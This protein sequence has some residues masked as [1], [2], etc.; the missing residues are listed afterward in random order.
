MSHVIGKGNVAG[1]RRTLDCFRSE[2]EWLHQLIARLLLQLSEIETAAPHP[3]RS[4][5]F[6]PPHLEAE[7]PQCR[8]QAQRRRLAQAPGRA[9]VLADEDLAVHEGTGSH[10]HR[11]AAEA[12]PPFGT[13][14]LYRAAVVVHQ[15]IGD[16]ILKDMQVTLLFH[17]LLGQPAVGELVRLRPG[18][19]HRRSAPPVEHPELYHSRI[20]QTAHFAAQRVDLPHHVALRKPADRRVA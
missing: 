9:L 8:P 15:Q 19:L 16:G 12:P 4:T 3:G 13:H 18:G 11:T 2:R 14:A 17:R 1:H 7:P 5:G 6:Q 20:Y 10:Y